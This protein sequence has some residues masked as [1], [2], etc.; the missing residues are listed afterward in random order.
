[1]R[2]LAILFTVAVA[3]MTVAACSSETGGDDKAEVLG[4]VTSRTLPPTTS[5]P[6]LVQ[7]GSQWFDEVNA[8]VGLSNES[9]NRVVF[10]PGVEASINNGRYFGEVADAAR[11]LGIALDMAGEP[12]SEKGLFEAFKQANREYEL[13]GRAYAACFG[14]EACNAGFARAFAAKESWLRA[15]AAWLEACACPA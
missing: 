14:D 5:P 13:A 9:Q 15:W 11:L 10:K 7:W 2:R 1:M 4:A 12:P 6:S 3:G 8:L